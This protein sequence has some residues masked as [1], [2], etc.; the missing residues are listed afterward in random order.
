MRTVEPL[1]EAALT[2]LVSARVW[3]SLDFCT[4]PAQTFP[5]FLLRS[6]VTSPVVELNRVVSNGGN[7]YM[8]QTTVAM[9]ACVTLKLW[10]EPPQSL[11]TRY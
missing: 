3:C 6:S 9:E 2:R 8:L 7:C 10:A 5:H 4:P 1:Q 11:R